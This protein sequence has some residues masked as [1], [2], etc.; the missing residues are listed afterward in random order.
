MIPTTPL[1]PHGSIPLV[2][3]G[4]WQLQGALCTDIVKKA[5][6]L[7]YT[8]IDTAYLYN[9]HQQIGKALQAT[10]RTSIFLTS[11]FQIYQLENCCLEKLC[12]QM[13][14]ELGTDYLDLLLLHCPDR[15]G[16]M[17][18]AL[19]ALD[20][21]KKTK[22]IR[23]AGVSNFTVRHLQDMLQWGIRPSVNQVEF[24]P[25]LY[26]KPL[27]E[28]CRKENIT[29]TSYRTFGKGALLT[30]PFLMQV[31]SRYKR[32]VAQILLRWCVQKNIPVIPKASEES[33]LQENL[34]VFNFTLSKEDMERLDTLNV[35]KRFCESVWSDFNYV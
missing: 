6:D 31:A 23:Y 5:L 35:E 12:D 15:A 8:H 16:P 33:H 13:L 30:D 10:D 27:W 20:Q 25:F 4:T 19:E 11:K 9:N 26:Q 34:D 21:L 28:F 3:L 1:T 14:Q 24:H 7:G 32:S 29:L 18:E 22:K 2:G 17:H